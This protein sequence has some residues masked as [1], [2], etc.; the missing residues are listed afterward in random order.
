MQNE[1]IG[2][3]AH[4][5]RVKSADTVALI[6][7]GRR[8]TY[9]ELAVRVDRLAAALTRRGIGRGDRVAYLGPNAPEFLETLFAVTSLG[10]IFVPLN[11]RLAAGEIAY[12]LS[13]SGSALLIVDPTL[14]ALAPDTVE[15]VEVGAAYEELLAAVDPTHVDHPVS[16]DDPAAILYTSG[17]TGRPKGAIL[18]HGNLTWNAINAIVDYDVTSREVALM[19]SPLFHVASLG[20]GALPTLLKGGT[21]VLQPRFDPAAVLAAIQQ[22]GITSLSGVPTTFQMLAE[23]PAWDSTDL[24]SLSKLT[25]GGSAVPAR[26]AEAYEKRGLAF[27]SGYGMTET[28]P[29]ATSLAPRHSASHATT[30]GLPHF[31]TSVRVVSRSGEPLPA[32]ELGEIQ[33]SGPNVIPGYWELPDASSAALDGPWFKSGDLGFLDADGFLTVADRAKDMFISGAENV[34]PAEVEQ[35]IMELDAVE[36]VAVIGVPDDKW[37]EVG[38]AV[39]IAV[40][41]TT[42]THDEIAAHLDGRIARYKIPKSTVLVD[43]LPRT[44]SG[45]VKKNELRERFGTGLMQ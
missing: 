36:S 33:V 5:R 9:A 10:A 7:G 42:V 41:G 22:H 2:D 35:L 17:T 27:S 30:S 26:V 8:T 28:A 6:D 11:I 15:T 14:A 20:M 25:C 34:Y 37:G 21:L 45:K 18:T 40:D 31:F 32:G 12:A 16:L 19:V 39:V 29:G 3:W 43:E 23:H 24:S 38:L 13:D 44:A 1:G 4:R